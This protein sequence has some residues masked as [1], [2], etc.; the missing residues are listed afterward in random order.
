MKCF[1]DFIFAIFLK[2]HKISLPNKTL[3]FQKSLISYP[4]TS[5]RSIDDLKVYRRVLS[6]EE[7][8]QQAKIAGL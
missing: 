3:F 5:N 7:I 8:K 6:E 4:N 1:K 2:V